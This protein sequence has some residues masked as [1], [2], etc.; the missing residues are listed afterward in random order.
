MSR[1][2]EPRVVWIPSGA[3]KACYVPIRN[4][5]NEFQFEGVI[6]LPPLRQSGA[7]RGKDHDRPCVIVAIA[8][9]PIFATTEDER[10]GRYPVIR[11]KFKA[12]DDVA[13]RL[14]ELPQGTYVIVRGQFVAGWRWTLP[15][16]TEF[17]VVEDPE[18]RA[19]GLGTEAFLD[20]ALG[21]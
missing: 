15:V 21:T 8:H 16:I 10:K 2:V 6:G 5:I 18:S 12:R 4:P 9:M 13:T 7:G 3:G 20:V 11:P 14:A 17:E 1:N 19:R